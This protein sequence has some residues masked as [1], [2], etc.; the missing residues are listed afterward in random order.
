MEGKITYHQ[1]VSFCGK[2][3]CK[4]CR[5]GKGHG[6]YWYAYQ[7][8]NGHTSRMYIGKQLPPDVAAAREEALLQNIDPSAALSLGTTPLSALTL[9][10]IDSAIAQGKLTDAV[11]LLDQFLVNDPTNETVVLR[12]LIVL[13]EL[14]RRG[15]AIRIY[16]RFA[17]VLQRIHGAAP[18]A[19]LKKVYEQIRR[20]EKMTLA[21]A[22]ADGTADAVR[23][24]PQIAANEN[25]VPVGRSHA[26]PMVGRDG[27][28]QELRL[29]LLEAEQYATHKLPMKK[30]VTQSIP[31]DTQRRPHCAILMGDAGIGKTRLAEEMAREAQQRGWLVLWG[32]S[33]VQESGIPYRLWLD[34]LRKA[35]QHSDWNREET[36]TAPH[37]HISDAGTPNPFISLT[38][39]STLLP[40][41]Q[42]LAR[43][44]PGLQSAEQEQLRLWEAAR[45]LL[46]TLS[47]RTP[48]VIVL[49]D[50]QWSDASSAEM[51][52]YLARHVHR[53][54]IL[55]VSTCRES[56]ITR[57]PLKPLIAHMQREH[58]VKVIHV[59]PL[60]SEQ[61]GQLIAHIPD[62]RNLAEP[63]V[64]QIQTQAAG[65][66]FFAEELARVMPATGTL[67]LPKTVTAA[68][69]QRISK[70]SKDCQQLLGN[71]AVLGGSFTL[72]VLCTMETS[73]QL[74]DEDA[75]LDLLDEA[76]KAGVLT[77]EGLGTRITYHFWHPLLV[78][79]LYERM[80]G[81]RRV[82]LHQ[83]VAEGMVR[84]Y[85]GREEE[86]AATITHH[87][88]Y[89]GAEPLKVAHYAEIAGNQAYTLSAYQEAQG[90]YRTAVSYLE[91]VSKGSAHL[92]RRLYLLEQ[93]AEC[94]NICG[95][96]EEARTLYT[97][98]I[99]LR[100]L[101]HADMPPEEQQDNI[102]VQALL[103]GEIGRTWR[104]VGDMLHAHEC[105]QQGM[106]LLTEAGIVSGLAW[107]RL[108]YHQGGV[109][110]QEGR[111]VE[112][113][114]V[115]QKALTLF[116]QVTQKSVSSATLA[117]TGSVQPMTRIQRT[118]QGDPIDL[119]RTFGLLGS[120]ANNVGH[121]TLALDYLNKALAIYEQHEKKREI[122]HVSCNMGH[123]YLKK[124]DYSSAQ[125][126][127]RRSFNLAESIGDEP[128][129]SVVYSNM[130][131]L[132]LYL[133]HFSEAEALYRQALSLSE[134]FKDKTYT[135]KWSIELAM[136]LQEAGRI[137]EATR[138]LVLGLHVG[139][140]MHNH[141]CISNALVAIANMRIAQAQMHEP[142]LWRLHTRPLLLA[143]LD[144]ERAL[145]LS[146]IEAETRL[147]A[148][149][150][151]AHIALILD[152]TQQARSEIT[153]VRDEAR[154][155]ELHHVVE[156]ADALLG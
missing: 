4:K 7:T 81:T 131:A 99:E 75:I 5:A 136:I 19:R 56:E 103:W 57:H 118:L 153:R 2:P 66:P 148:Q 100:K 121:V 92:S 110:E 78:T 21:S 120:L 147:N 40:E 62:T 140:T 88:I 130:A 107:A 85:A 41:L 155:L 89:G 137:K 127:L 27:E 84:L 23:P 30:R 152:D 124:A 45:D 32:R 77:E 55:L 60:S 125:A 135:S 20:G 70:L 108:Y 93:L 48:L 80:S 28:L 91:K 34:I 106:D 16:Q 116:M 31:L 143:R 117:T 94:T 63:F 46:I 83:R 111:N 36:T 128:L 50:V 22:L 42:V 17:D 14:K 114:E 72:S 96:F 39:L 64:Q 134:R 24:S 37:E 126:A 47:E 151:L 132:A 154:T 141:P 112:G 95:N 113:T 65:N 102:P 54:P 142:Q 87:L 156:R 139:R 119:G 10:T 69:D 1:Q 9:Q 61:I 35:L 26:N 123:I 149:L 43:P 3:G 122:A 52:G 68:L 129:T 76:L 97:H 25:V 144:A 145:A 12:L 115:A 146:G 98:L 133:H 150:A 38:M 6:P 104:Y 49:D 59:E 101:Y 105:C 11:L 33:Y 53:Y 109:Y 71:A 90:H 58:S 138:Y 8:K 79:H 73:G 18:S 86:V 15:E 67:T 51:L 29:M 44:L 74:A 13:T 82:R